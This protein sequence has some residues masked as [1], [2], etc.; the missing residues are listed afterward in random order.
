LVGKPERKGKLGRPTCT[1]EDAIKLD[2]K[3]IGSTLGLHLL[4]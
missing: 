4:A 3:E 2:F 1:L